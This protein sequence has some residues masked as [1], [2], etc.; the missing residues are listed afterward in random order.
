[1]PTCRH[2]THELAWASEGTATLR[3]DGIP[4]VVSPESAVWIPLGVPHKVPVLR[5]AIVFPLW[6]TDDAP[7]PDWTT[8]TA[9]WVSADLRSQLMRYIQSTFGQGTSASIERD[10]LLAMLPAHAQHEPQLPMPG[11]PR[12]SFVAERLLA[13]PADGRSIEDWAREIGTSSKT[14]QRAFVSTTGLN[15]VEWRVRARLNAALPMLAQGVAVSRIAEQVGYSSATGFIAAFRRQF[16]H[17]PTAHGHVAT[18][19]DAVPTRP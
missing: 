8:T 16:G 6:F 11:D 7:V 12:A 5:K 13:D 9:V 19:S 4:W 18:G 17:P 10:R 15:F 3:I 1:M 2:E 14:L